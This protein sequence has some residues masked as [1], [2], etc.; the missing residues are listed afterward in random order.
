[1]SCD[2][3]SSDLQVESLECYLPNERLRVV[4]SMYL[5]S[6]A[7]VGVTLLT[8]PVF[9]AVGGVVLSAGMTAMVLSWTRNLLYVPTLLSTA[10]VGGISELLGWEY[11][12]ALLL[13]LLLMTTI[14]TAGDLSAF[15]PL[16]TT[17]I[18]AWADH[19]EPP[20]IIIPILVL[21]LLRETFGWSVRWL[22][23]SLTILL[24]VVAGG[25]MYSDTGLIGLI[26]AHLITNIAGVFV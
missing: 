5:L 18:V 21:S 3:S 6:I 15:V 13:K 23:L 22:N 14:L 19:L 2:Y 20:M 26:T 24:S 17:A 4:L 16:F 12:T 8:G 25:L 10:L 9:F 7:A 11:T 1:M